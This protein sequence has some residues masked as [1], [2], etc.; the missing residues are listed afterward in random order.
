VETSALTNWKGV[1]R[2]GVGS[3]NVIQLKTLDEFMLEIMLFS[4]EV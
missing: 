3:G 1:E 2:K 4:T